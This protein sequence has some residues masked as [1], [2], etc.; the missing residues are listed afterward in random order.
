MG[1]FD[2]YFPMGLGTSRFPIRG[3]SDTAGIEKSVA[4]VCHA[5]DKGINYIDTAYPYSAGMAQVVLKEAFR[6]T[7]KPFGVTVKVMHDMDKTAD[8]ARRRVELQLAAM[9]IEKASFFVCWTVSSHDSF[10]EIMSK[11]GIYDGALK[12]KEEGLVD[13]ICFSTHAPPDDIAR[14]VKSGAFE[15][16]TISYSILNAS[17]MR[18]VLD[19]ALKYKVDVAVMNPLGGGIIV[20]NREF[21]A[22]ARAAGERDTVLGALRFA[23]AHPA[24]K[25]LLSGVSSRDELDENL[26]TFIEPDPES[27]EKR[28]ARISDHVRDLHDFC[29]GCDYCTGCPAGIP[30]SE[31]MKKRNALLFDVSEAYNRTAPELVQNLCLFRSHIGEWLPDTAENPCVRCGQCEAKCTQNLKIMDALDDM[32]ARADQVG[33]TLAARKSRTEE[34]LVDK[35]YLRVGLYPNGGFANMIVEYYE[36]FF[37]KPEFEW[38]QFN[39]DPK[40]WGEMSGGLPIYSPT[41]ILTIK[42]NIILVCTYKYDREIVED[43]KCYQDDGIKIVKLHRE[44]DVPWVF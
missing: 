3:P 21:F 7:K 31:I 10:E 4:L 34:L 11:G 30:V 28:L 9:G 26:K 17:V 20:Q 24:V 6:Q 35:N 41:E 42:P 33:F 19:T 18:S 8:D 16:V 1:A 39:S 2:G 44:T 15:G 40:M 27:A 5:L 12:L 32:F 13:H 25:I 14:I 29:T 38:V 36:K 37:G 43:L 23:K 22:F